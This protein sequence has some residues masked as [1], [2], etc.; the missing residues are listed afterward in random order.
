MGSYLYLNIGS[1]RGTFC[2]YK[3]RIVFR[4]GML[5]H[6]ITRVKLM[7]RVCAIIQACIVLHNIATKRGDM[8]LL[9]AN[10]DNEG[11]GNF[12]R[13]GVNPAH[14]DPTVDGCVKRQNIVDNYFTFW[15]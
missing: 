10:E 8:W 11:N 13:L 15:H 6:T 3:E 4:F 1:H 9:D 7:G 14:V 12:D 5:K 2:K